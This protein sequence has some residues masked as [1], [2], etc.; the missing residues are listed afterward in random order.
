MYINSGQTVIKRLITFRD[1]APNGAIE[2]SGMPV[3]PVKH[4]PSRQ[5]RRS[6][7]EHRMCSKNKAMQSASLIFS[8]R[9]TGIENE[10]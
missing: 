9:E 1:E 8:E 7:F 3:A 5:T 2:G 10:L 4:G 6:N